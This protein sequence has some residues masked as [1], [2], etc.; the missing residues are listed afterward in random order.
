MKFENPL[1]AH[2]KDKKESAKEAAEHSEKKHE[3]EHEFSWADDFGSP[4]P[5]IDAL[6]AQSSLEVV[7]GPN[8]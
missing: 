7:N 1:T 4:E 6:G 2:E 5:I 8:E 3:K